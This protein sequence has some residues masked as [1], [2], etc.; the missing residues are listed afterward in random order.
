MVYASE[1]VL[2]EDD[3]QS[4]ESIWILTVINMKN[5]KYCF[6]LKSVQNNHSHL[7][8][9]VF[10]QIC[11]PL[12]EVIE[13]DEKVKIVEIF[14]HWDNVTFYPEK[15]TGIKTDSLL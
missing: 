5:T 1:N 10:N 11:I 13:I 6:K 7:F 12:R 8:L 4:N 2:W 14:I 3:W 15:F 9:T